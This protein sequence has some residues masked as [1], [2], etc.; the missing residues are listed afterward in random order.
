MAFHLH[1]QHRA[2]PPS[3]LVK[4]LEDD[5]EVYNICRMRVEGHGRPP[6]AL[7]NV[8]QHETIFKD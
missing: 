2:I 8:Q 7:Q 4:Q 6:P 5:I 1:Q 3:E